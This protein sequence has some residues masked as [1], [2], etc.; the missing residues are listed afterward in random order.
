MAHRCKLSLFILLSLADFGLTWLLIGRGDGEVYEG[1]PLARW[2]LTA[3]GWAGLLAFKTSTVLAVVGIVWLVAR[4]RPRLGGHLLA[5]SCAA[6]AVVVL[7]SGALAGYLS[8]SA[9]DEKVEG[10]FTVICPAETRYMD[11]ARLLERLGADLAAGRCSLNEGMHELAIS[12]RGQEP[13]LYEKLRLIY[14]N[15]SDAECLAASLIRSASNHCPRAEDARRTVDRLLHDFIRTFA[16]P[17]PWSAQELL[18]F[19]ESVPS[20]GPAPPVATELAA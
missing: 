13:D 7:Y 4:H 18:R 6:L 14:P 10:V 2:W 9:R 1:N 12:E 17:P 11:Y 15:C 8:R 3:G 19:P 16:T 20:T 5:F